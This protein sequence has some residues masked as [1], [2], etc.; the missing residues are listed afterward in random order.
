MKVVK[1]IPGSGGGFYC[2][3]CLR[4]SALVRAMRAKGHDVM[5][6][7]MYLP[8]YT[9]DPDLT[10]GSPVFFGGINVY[11]KERFPFL[12]GIPRWVD[13]ALDS[14]WMLRLA[15]G[16]AG[17]TRAGG[18]GPMTLAMIKADSEYHRRE[19][20][21]M[22]DYLLEHEQPDAVHIATVML[23]GL[24]AHI[25]K[26][27]G[28]P[29]VVSLQDEDTWIDS[30]ESPYNERCW[31]AIRERLGLVDRFMT[32]SR[33][34]R[35]V[36]LSRLPVPGDRLDVVHIG[37]D[38]SGYEPPPEPPA[39]PVIG[40]LSKLTPSL[41]LGLLVDALIMLRKRPGLE[42]VRLMAMGGKTGGDGRFLTVLRNRLWAEG[43]EGAADF[44]DEFDRSSR[45]E[46]LRSI[47]VLSVPMPKG[48][49]FGTFMIE[50]MAAGVPVVQPAAGAFPEI[51]GETG[52]GWLCEPGSAVALADALERALRAPDEVKAAGERG[53]AAVLGR[54][55]VDSMADGVVDVYR[56]AI[57]NRA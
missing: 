25:R 5:M 24:A 43:M 35:D 10:R 48:E 49:A 46:F 19:T 2:E 52:G 6:A 12:A 13:K 14:R 11:L 38:P 1:I 50:A 44:L 31:D 40:Y 54:F 36:V 26:R 56:H 4:D 55:T 47:T 32:V 27:T 51:I 23:I 15:A 9:D 20:G 8:V 37:I 33:W 17:S 57:Q 28:A 22:L 53:R 41:G 34:Y 3:N 30:L 21:R 29:I 42:S 16:Q 39:P 7:P 18:L 45:I